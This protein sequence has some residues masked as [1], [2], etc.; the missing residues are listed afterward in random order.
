MKRDDEIRKL[1]SASFPGK[2]NDQEK[3]RWL[4]IATPYELE[5][6]KASAHRMGHTTEAEMVTKEQDRR[7]LK[8]ARD[9]ALKSIPYP[10][11][12]N[13]SFWL[14]LVAAVGAAIAAVPVVLNWYQR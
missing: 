7:I 10:W 14:M 13:W 5:N 9:A 2:L 12:I 3:E 1:A 8:D 11:Y 4:Q 6:S